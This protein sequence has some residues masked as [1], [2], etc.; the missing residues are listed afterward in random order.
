MKFQTHLQNILIN[1]K[2]FF[3]K[4]LGVKQTIF[5]NTFW[6]A[7]ADG[8]TKFLKLILIIY[9]A[10]ILGATDYGRFNFALAF[11]GLFA[12]F[13]DL[14]ISSITTREIS[15]DKEKEKEFSSILS[16]KLLLVIGTLILIL[17]G[18]FFIT[19]DYLNRKLIWILG[20]FAVVEGFSGIIFAFIQARQKMEYQAWTK[21]LEALIV[22]AAGF[23]VILNFPSVE[24][25]SYSYLFA[26]LVALIFIL[27]FFHFRISPLKISFQKSIWKRILSMSW[28]LA[29]AGVFGVIYTNTDS[30]MMGY[31]GQITPIGWYN[32]AQKITNAALII[33]GLIGVSFFPVLSKFF[34]KSKEKLQTIWNYFF[35]LMIFLAV[36]TVAG[37]ILLAPKIIDFIYDPSYLPSILAFKMLI[38]M[39]GI[40]LLCSP[41]SQVLVVA[42]QQKKLFWITL[43]GAIINVILNSIL[44]PRYSLYGA[45]V[46]TVVTIFLI[47]LLLFRFTLKLTP[48]KPFNLKF[49]FGFLSAIFATIPMYFII[50]Q[51]RIYNLNVFPSILIG[52]AIYTLIYLILKT[53]IKYSRLSLCKW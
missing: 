32:A 13:S 37:G 38:I 14:G 4:N 48:I 23:F 11:V 34:T 5:K 15:Q 30:I 42:H 44:I 19:P 3:L 26:S 46:A 12:F 24:N 49:L 27:I 40:S 22:T 8:I 36:P 52:A 1:P 33:P 47:L 17:I 25:L 29:I 31:F 16:L 2:S 51:P 6:L 18:S 35:E 21:I 41:F 28:P 53:L 45:A 43:L 10:R 39:A 50:S 9:V 20:V 7:A